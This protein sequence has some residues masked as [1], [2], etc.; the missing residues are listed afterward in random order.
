MQPQERPVYKQQTA[1]TPGEPGPAFQGQFTECLRLLFISLLDGEGVIWYFPGAR[2]LKKGKDSMTFLE[3][4]A[5]AQ[6]LPHKG[7]RQIYSLFFFSGKS[8]I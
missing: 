4:T 6:I 2:T 8:E 1:Y 3:L 5:V 7:K